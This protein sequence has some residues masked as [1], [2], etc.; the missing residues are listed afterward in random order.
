MNTTK[1]LG[2]ILLLCV[3]VFLGFV[4]GQ[5]EFGADAAAPLRACS[6]CAESCCPKTR[7]CSCLHTDT[8]SC[9]RPEDVPAVR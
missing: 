5:C 2:W 4:A 6:V 8:C 1:A 7:N 9:V 3:L